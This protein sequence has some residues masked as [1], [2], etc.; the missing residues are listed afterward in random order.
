MS[1]GAF[2]ISLDFEQHWGMR[3]LHTVERSRA[4]LLGARAAVPALLALFTEFD[5]RATWATV[6][7]LF[8]E[9]RAEMLNALPASR[10]SYA[11]A[12]L[13]PYADLGD[14]GESER[15]DP[16]HFAPSL[17]RRIADTPG[18]EIATHT[19]SHYY[20]CEPGQTVDQFRADLDAACRVAR[21][22]IG[23][24][25]E[26]IVFP[27]NQMTPAHLTVCRDVGL[28][29][30]RGN[31]DHWAYAATR[32]DVA[33]SPARRA[34]RLADAYV[35]LT[36]RHSGPM[37]GGAALPVDVPASRYLRPYG[38]ALRA[39]EPL[40]L[41]RITA[42]LETAAA[43]R[44]V[45]HLWWHPHDFG[46]HVREN[47]AFLRRVLNRFAR[48]RERAGMESLTMSDVARRRLGCAEERTACR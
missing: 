18:Q 44:R 42:E 31:P 21:R 10:P 23:R 17:I 35:P 8:F 38:R 41:R 43:D 26:S 28:L 3:D 22:R 36:G 15:D 27:R 2:V 34:L 7:L 12:G 5:V 14:V 33:Q 48:V 29:A 4:A 30:H 46:L 37:G 1:V 6:G 39:L 47:L 11:T 45:F 32:R 25:P 20:C 13:S 24:A 19:F 16:F 9:S 40:R